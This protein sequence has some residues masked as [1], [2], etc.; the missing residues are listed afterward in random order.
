V[1]SDCSGQYESQLHA[2]QTLA[3]VFPAV[4]P[5]LPIFW[6]TRTGA[7]VMQP[8]AAPVIGGMLSTLVH[9]L[10]VTPVN[11]AWLHERKLPP[12]PH[13]IPRGMRV[14]TGNQ[15]PNSSLN[16]GFCWRSPCAASVSG[17]SAPR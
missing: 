9:I 16:D 13:L 5:R 1:T 2:R 8:I 6:S 10:V 11:F 12:S 14:R 7:E 15:R 4:P 17:T 3:C